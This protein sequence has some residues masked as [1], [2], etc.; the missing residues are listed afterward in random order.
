MEAFNLQAKITLDSS[1][2]EKGLNQAKGMATSFG[3]KLKGG[4]AAAAKVGTVAIGAASAAVAAFGK[5][6][7]D[8]GLTFDS[9]MSQVAATMGTTTDQIQDLRDFAQEMGRTTAF[10]ATEAADAMNILAM[11]GYSAEENMA[12]LPAVLNMAAA[13]GLGIA[14]AADYATGIIAGF[15]NETLDAATIADKLATVA[16]NAKGDVRSFGEG[17]STVAGMANTTGQSMQDMTVALGILGNNNYSAAEAGNALSRTLKNLYQPTDVAAKA[18]KELGVSAYDA[19]GNARPLQDVLLDLNSGLDGMNEQAK[20]QALSNIF[21]AAT[22]KSV[23]ALLNNAGDA[24]DKLDAVI[25]DSTGNAEE[26]A[27]VQLD[28]LQGDITLFKSALE[29]AQIALSDELTP[30]LREFVQFGSDGLSRIT[31]AFKTDGLSGALDVV[32]ELV[33]EMTTKLVEKIPDLIEVGG[34][35]LVAIGEGI[36]NAMPTLLTSLVELGGKIVE[37]IS[38]TL[39]EKF[40]AAG[41]AF[42]GFIEIASSAISL[43]QEFW[44]EHGE[45]IVS[46]AQEIW[47]N[48]KSAVS[49]AVETVQ[50]IIQTVV[51]V[52]QTIWDTWGSD[53]VQIATLAWEFIKTV[54]TTAITEVQNIITT[55]TSVISAIWDAWGSTIMAAAQV[56]WQGIQMAITVVLNVIKGLITAA[57]AAIQGDWS[58]AWNA[59]KGVASTIWNAIKSVITAAINAVKSVITSVLNSIKSVFTSVWNGIKSTVSSAINGV[60]STISSGINAAYSTVSSVLDS[61]GEKFSSIFESAKSTV[62]SAIEAIKGAFNFSWSL[63]HL[64]LP[65]ISV[66]GG[67]APFG[68]GG[69]GSLPQFSIDWYKKAMDDPYMLDGA[70][71]FGMMGD[72]L[73]GGGEAGREIIVGEQRALDMIAD[74]SRSD[75]LVNRVDRLIRLLEYYL[76]KQSTGISSKAIDRALGAMI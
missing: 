26:M 53:I 9:S 65:H 17:L 25:K 43:V 58:G 68:I 29:G 74:A 39:N 73:L 42:D 30:A 70:M 22:L 59:V 37:T 60:K 6:S 69:K 41:A 3:S 57:T 38:D 33:S 19:E 62:T 23:P 40:P 5:S 55:V 67:E 16:S 2:Y 20:N 46:K 56:V 4:L 7:I 8:A 11:A 14:E 76:P 64:N 48:V 51:S 50:T 52:I 36:V 61:I 45:E 32:T 10:S 12:T 49:T 28:N 18:M 54:V 13:G 27:A 34:K 35:L 31:E 72:K 71:L 66:T 63:P 21:D 47:E 24:W 15:S 75:E 1:E 44:A